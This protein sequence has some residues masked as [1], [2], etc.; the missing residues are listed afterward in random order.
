MVT[1]FLIY[2]WIKQ[3]VRV[4]KS[5][6]VE[7]GLTMRQILQSSMR[8]SRYMHYVINEKKRGL[9]GWRSVKD[10]VKILVITLLIAL[11]KM[12]VMGGEGSIID[13]LVDMHIVPLAISFEYD[14]CDYLKALEFQLKRDNPDYK[15][16]SRR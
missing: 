9:F 15:K 12:L 3:V 10:V 4:N 8:M 5:F 6:A 1:I 11:L 7:R 16:I 14:P 13:R 2:P